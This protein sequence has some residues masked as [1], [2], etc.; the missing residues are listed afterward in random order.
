MRSRQS[1]KRR[2]KSKCVIELLMGIF[3]ISV[4]RG[5]MK[6]SD[7]DKDIREKGDEKSEGERPGEAKGRS[8]DKSKERREKGKERKSEQQKD[9]NKV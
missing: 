2:R 9:T 3:P 7:S 4:S 8:R 5:G 6:R 1:A